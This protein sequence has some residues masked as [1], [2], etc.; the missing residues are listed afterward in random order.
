VR[1]VALL[2]G[3]LLLPATSAW[4][5]SPTVTLDRPISRI[6]S[7]TIP[8]SASVTGA[9]QRV[10]FSVRGVVKHVDDSA[11]FGG[12]F[13]T[14]TVE[15]GPATI[16]AV[17]F[18]DGG[19]ST[20]ASVDVTIDNTRPRMEVIGPDRERFV[21]GSTQ[22]WTFSAADAG[23][24]FSHFR[25]SVQ[26][27]GTTPD[28]GSCTDAASFVAQ[29]QPVG[30]Y[31][32]SVRAFDNAGNF[33]QQGRDFK[34]EAPVPE[35][36]LPA[37]ALVGPAAPTATVAVAEKAEA[38]QILVALGFSFTSTARATKL[39]NLVVRNVP[40]GATVTVTCPKG[41]AKKRYTRRNVSGGSLHLKRVLKKRIKVG[42]E[43][44]V[45]VSKPG[46]SSAVK[47]LTIR[48]RKA[49][50]VTTLCQPEGSSEPAAC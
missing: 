2:F 12:D 32:F 43:I 33:A 39:A 17:A 44:T 40:R 19:D 26:P 8:V 49:P 21:P 10:E 47:V 46:A 42:T 29:D 3:F 48:A 50:L 15:D 7:R 31:T 11:P 34:I 14:T 1:T 18:S 41:C 25:C 45:I 37:P 22:R 35:A 28:F 6:V 24:G 38:P 16:S 27:I 4:A 9:V 20:T 5:Q 13:D 23:S 36:T 30:V